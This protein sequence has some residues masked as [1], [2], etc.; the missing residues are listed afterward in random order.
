MAHQMVKDFSRSIDY[1]KTRTDIDTAKL[2]FYG[3]SWGGHLGG[4]I[5]AIEERLSVNI[6]ITGGFADFRSR[7][8]PEADEINYVSRS[9]SRS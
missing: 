9:V 5:P 3:H 6:L 4:I 1:L 7:D 2:G 8:Y